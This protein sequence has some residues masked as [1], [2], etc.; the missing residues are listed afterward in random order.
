[1]IDERP[2]ASGK[3]VEELDPVHI[4]LGDLGCVVSFNIIYSPEHPIVLGLPW[5]DLYNPKIDWRKREIQCPPKERI[6]VRD[7]T[8]A[9]LPKE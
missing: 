6:F 1:V 7:R 9:S 4:L 5:F 8:Q 3:I 2:I